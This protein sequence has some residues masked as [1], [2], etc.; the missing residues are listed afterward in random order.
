MPVFLTFTPGERHSGLAIRLFRGRRKDPAFTTPSCTNPDLNRWIGFNEP[1]LCPNADG[2]N[3]TDEI[4]E[5]GVIVD[6]PEYDV[7]RYITA[8][9]PLCCVY[10]FYVMVR[11]V[12]P[13]LFGFRMCPHCPHCAKGDDPCMDAFGSNATSMGGCAGRCDAMIGAV[14]SQKADGV[15][16]I[17]CFLFLQM[18]PQQIDN[19]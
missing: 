8:R 18:I 10:A 5:E 16:H 2:N 1:S 15:L 11:V 3:D 6:L 14:E 12:L 13:C 9:D 19:L 4:D 17:H 7:R